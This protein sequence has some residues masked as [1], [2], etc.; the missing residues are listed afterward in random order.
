MS[1]GDIDWVKRAEGLTPRVR[2]FVNGRWEFQDARS[3]LDKFSPRDGRLL[4]RFGAGDAQ[5]VDKAVASTQRAFEDG[6]WSKAP[7]QERK[8]ALLKLAALI[9]QHREELALLD[10]LDTGKPISDALHFDVPAAVANLRFN[11]ESADKLYG[12]VYGVDASSLSYELRRPIGVVAGIVGWNFPLY[13]AVQKIGPVLVTGNCLVLKPSEL[14]SFSA[15]RLA[16]LAIEAGVPEGVLNVIHGGAGVGDALAQHPEVRLLTFT[17]SSR[18]GKQLLIA[19]GQSNMK[20]L[21]LECGG[22][23]PNIVFD[24]CPDVEA[25][26]DGV[27]A[28]AFWNQGQVCVASSRLLIQES[29][30]P[31]FLEVLIK[32]VSALRIGDPLSIKT[33]FGAL[34]SRNH[35]HKMLSLRDGAIKEGARLIHQADAPLPFEGGFYVQPMIFD[36]VMPEHDIAQEE[37]FGPLLSVMSFR[38]EA[39]AIRVANHT[40]YGLSAMLWTKDVG[41]AHR[42]SHAIEAGHIVVNSTSRPVGGVGEGV[43]SVGGH[44]QSG[45]GTEGGLEGLEMYTSKSAVQIFV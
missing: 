42:L 40:M 22:K 36:D 31:A 26:A 38:G 6:R 30:K 3:L 11:A 33:R 25:V 23:A 39:D 34:V 14:T 18:T 20:R 9:E 17:G 15:S 29:I 19:A 27:M 28:S 41:R 24:D 21:V 32:K 12:K 45:I 13:L 43:L 10:C 7:V 2:N 44:K 35:R 4:C 1:A 5:D 8:A 16:E 37:V